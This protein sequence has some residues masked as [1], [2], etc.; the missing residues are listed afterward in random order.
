[1]MQSPLTG[2]HQMTESAFASQS[3]TQLRITVRPNTDSVCRMSRATSYL[4]VALQ[5]LA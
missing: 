2:G 3:N 5:S 1:M 4:S